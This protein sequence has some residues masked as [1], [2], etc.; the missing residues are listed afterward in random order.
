VGVPRLKDVLLPDETEVLKMNF[1]LNKQS[2]TA[3]SECGYYQITSALNNGKPYYNS[4]YLPTHRSIEGT[5]DKEA[6]KRA[7]QQHAQRMVRM[8][9]TVTGV[10]A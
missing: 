6:A 2:G 7:C 8:K 1:K 3:T 4:M 9:E 5:Y 10:S